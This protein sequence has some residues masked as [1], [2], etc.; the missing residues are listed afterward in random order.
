MP[1]RPNIADFDVSART[2]LVHGAG[3]VDRLGVI[4]REVGCSSVLLVTMPE[5]AEAGH[6]DRAVKALAGEGV[7][8][9]IF[10]GVRQ[11]P[12]SADVETCAAAAREAGVDGFVGLGG[13]SAIDTARG[14]NFIRT[15]GG[16]MQDYRGYGKAREPMMP[17][18]AVPTTAGTGS[19]CQSY[20]L[21]S[22]AETH[23][24]MACGDPKAAAVV[25]VL[26]PM[27]TVTAPREVTAASGFDAV[28][29]AVESAVT[30]TRNAMST[31]YA[32]EAFRLGVRA[33]PRTLS[34]PDD[35]EARADMQIAAAFAGMAIEAS[36][37]GA[38]HAAA[39]PLT[40]SFD[41]VHGHAVA[42]MLPHVVRF[43]SED[44]DVAIAYRDLMAGAGL[45]DADADP[46][47]ASIALAD[48]LV[49]LREEGELPSSIA[50]CGVTD[51]DLGALAQAASMQWTGQH[52]PRPVAA[53]DF[54]ALYGA[55]IS[56]GELAS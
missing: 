31:L 32:R 52:N 33:L 15:N 24:K 50:R 47:M 12:T 22:D 45:V 20:A 39:N 27:L 36:M 9:T 26:D 34:K 42:L 23:E 10:D 44:P 43:N 6:V 7:S 1:D 14:A 17:L 37:L 28:S 5:L 3:C 8:A 49:A 46:E 40:A 21:I 55:S 41:V 29:H 38:A 30:K 2:R 25:A 56:Q 13:G 19:E 51:T 54:V 11:N 53:E 35:L 48:T 18:I 16:R 4:A